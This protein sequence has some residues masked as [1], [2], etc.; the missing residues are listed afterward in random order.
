MWFAVVAFAAMASVGADLFA[1]SVRV[2]AP[3][4]INAQPVDRLAEEGDY[5]WQDHS[6]SGGTP[7]T[8]RWFREGVELRDLETYNGGYS[9]I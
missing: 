4:V 6:V 1:S 8:F 2:A 3:P 9:V 7:L 5:V